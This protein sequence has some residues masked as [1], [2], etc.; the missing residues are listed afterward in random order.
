MN[1][2]YDRRIIVRG[3]TAD[4]VMWHSSSKSVMPP[5]RVVPVSIEVVFRDAPRKIHSPLFEK[6]YEVE[7][8]GGVAKARIPL[9]EYEFL[10]VEY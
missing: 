10:V 8:E 3:N 9:D 2:T 4:P 6:K 5:R 1:L 7:V